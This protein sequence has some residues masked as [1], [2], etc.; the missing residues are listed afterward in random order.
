M[1]NARIWLVVRPS[2]GLPLLL[3][4]VLLIALLVHTAILTNTDWYPD[5]FKGSNAAVE[6][7]TEV[8]DSE[9]LEPR[10]SIL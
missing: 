10:E 6:S 1:Y 2:V 8:A 3:G 7:A 4:T 5:Y 9:A